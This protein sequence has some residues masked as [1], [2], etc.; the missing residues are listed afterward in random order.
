MTFGS[1]VFRMAFSHLL[2][3]HQQLDTDGVSFLFFFPVGD[4]VSEP[5][6]P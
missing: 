3:S 5:V 1:L 2:T 4:V 6:L